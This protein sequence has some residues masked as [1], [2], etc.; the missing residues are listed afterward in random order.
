MCDVHRL[1][2]EKARNWTAS[3]RRDIR[4]GALPNTETANL[5]LRHG[6]PST[7]DTAENSSMLEKNSAHRR[8]RMFYEERPLSVAVHRSISAVTEA[9]IEE[10]SSSI[11]SV[12]ASTDRSIDTVSVV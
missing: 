4:G 8:L 10:D 3:N 12:S 11:I 9:N 7:I 5:H 6:G 2:R 1:L